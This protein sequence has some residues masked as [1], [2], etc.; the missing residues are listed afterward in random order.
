[1]RW[2]GTD[3]GKTIAWSGITESTLLNGVVCEHTADGMVFRDN[4]SDGIE[5][6][7]RFNFLEGAYCS[8]IEGGSTAN[9]KG[10]LDVENGAL[11]RVINCQ[12]EHGVAYADS[13]PAESTIIVRGT[14]YRSYLGIIEKNNFGAGL[15]R[16]RDTIVLQNTAGTV[17][18]ENYFF[19][20]DRADIRIE[21]ASCGTSVG[22]RNMGRGR[23]PLIAAGAYTDASRRLAISLPPDQHGKRAVGTRGVWHPA[24]EVLTDFQRDWEPWNLEIML[25]EAGLVTFNGG[26][27]GGRLEGPICTFPRWLL[28]HDDAWL[29]VA[30][31][32]DGSV[33]AVHLRASDGTLMIAHR[34]MGTQL[35]LSNTTYSAVIGFPYTEGP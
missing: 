29:H 20:S 11:W 9:R 5:P 6:A 12:M 23:R 31:I 27:S 17:I 3:A 10:A 35:S 13:A 15:G 16:V 26:L 14:R 19:L 28:P 18:D 33:R 7:Y 21:A 2:S 34:L 24:G 32:A 22:T 30:V 4:I 8:S 25:T 1:V